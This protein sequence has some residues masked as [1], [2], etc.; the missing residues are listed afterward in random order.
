MLIN[1]RGEKNENA[2]TYCLKRA[3][4][5]PK[6]L[7]LSPV[8]IVKYGLQDDCYTP[9]KF[10]VSKTNDE[11]RIT[12]SLGQYIIVWNFEDVKNGIIDAY[13]IRNVNEFVLGNTTKFDKNQ[14]L[15]TMTKK[16]RL[17]NETISEI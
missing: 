2:F 16:V 14:L 6:T 1:T 11:T 17:Q 9:A 5:K 4:R 10:N 15:I 8:D 12:S 7:K 3:R 13:K